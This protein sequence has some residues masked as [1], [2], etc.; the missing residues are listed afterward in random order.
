VSDIRSRV[1]AVLSAGLRVQ[2][3]EVAPFQVWHQFDVGRLSDAVIAELGLRKQS[4][5]GE[6]VGII[7]GDGS[8]Y[9][10]HRYVTDWIP[11]E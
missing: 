4:Q 8:D 1:A 5:S 6:I 10:R 11:G 7:E 3:N 2:Q 9:A